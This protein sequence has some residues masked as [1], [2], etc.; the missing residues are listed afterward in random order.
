MMRLAQQPFRPMGPAPQPLIMPGF[1]RPQVLQ[2]PPFAP[3]LP[4]RDVP[5]L[6]RL[7]NFVGG[8]GLLAAP[9]A[10]P[11]P[12][13][14]AHPPRIPPPNAV[15]GPSSSHSSLV[16][17]PLR[18][19]AGSHSHSSPLAPSN[20]TLDLTTDDVSHASSL[21]HGGVSHRPV[22][23]PVVAVAGPSRKPPQLASAR[24]SATPP[25]DVS[26]LLATDSGD[27]EVS[28]EVT[29]SREQKAPSRARSPTRS[30]LA[31]LV[32]PTQVSPPSH[33]LPSSSKGML[34]ASKP[35]RSHPKPSSGVGLAVQHRTSPSVLCS[36]STPRSDN[37]Q[38][39]IVTSLPE[40][41]RH[42][43][44]ASPRQLQPPPDTAAGSD[45]DMNPPLAS[46]AAQA[47]SSKSSGPAASSSPALGTK[48]RLGMGHRQAG[49]SNKKFKPPV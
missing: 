44:R 49:Y 47:A 9:P 10:H 5:G 25:A 4:G 39:S 26:W 35:A 30:P 20:T 1:S 48:R 18:A 27:D 38:A 12:R 24:V 14:S 37:P 45:I 19:S 17:Q 13:P 29:I 23:S 16:P 8:G 7:Q 3:Y 22:S 33:S 2:A 41:A 32:D 21:P 42:A 36:P 6:S 15:A 46:V 34:A 11:A 40:P 28:A 43:H 31:V